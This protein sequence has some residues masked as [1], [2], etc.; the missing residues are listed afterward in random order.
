ML[1][2]AHRLTDPAGFRSATREGRRSSSRTLVTH[3]VAG[4]GPVRAGFVVSKQVGGAVVR[5]RVKRR[6]RHA[7]RELLVRDAL[8]SSGCLVVRALPASATASYGELA[9][10]L[11]RCLDRVHAPAA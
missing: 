8:P 10:D 5:N 11:A 3:Y 2:A 6:L 4:T 7:V 1:P 9:A